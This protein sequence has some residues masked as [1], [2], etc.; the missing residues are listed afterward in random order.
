MKN[1][2]EKLTLA[3]K[4][5]DEKEEDLEYEVKEEPILC[6]YVIKP[7][8]TGDMFRDAIRLEHS[9]GEVVENKWGWQ[10]LCYHLVTLDV[11]YKKDN[12]SKF[13]SKACLLAQIANILKGIT[14]P[15]SVVYETAGG[16]RVVF[17]DLH[18][19]SDVEWI[20]QFALD[21]GADKAYMRIS[22]EQ[23]NY[24]AR[25]SHK[26]SRVDKADPRTPVVVKRVLTQG[27]WT[28]ITALQWLELHDNLCGVV[29]QKD[30]SD[31][32][33]YLA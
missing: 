28:D 24:R 9:G 8:M 17:E 4:E 23:K 16:F 26:E 5:A 7:T 18:S 25:M 31:D 15:A 3:F 11:D 33:Y 27:A 22:Y 13:A 30:W 10:V 19:P 12:Q 21:A 1:L 32:L 20:A 14:Y 2:I 29:D 6:K